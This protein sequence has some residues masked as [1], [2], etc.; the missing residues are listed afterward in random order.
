MSAVELRRLWSNRQPPVVYSSPSREI[1]LACGSTSISSI[2]VGAY[3]DS[4]IG[5]GQPEI[6][7]GEQN[8]SVSTQ[9]INRGVNVYNCVFESP[10]A[11]GEE[12]SLE[13]I[14]R[15]A[16]SQ[17]AFIYNDMLD[18]PLIS[19]QTTSEYNTRYIWVRE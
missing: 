7:I 18:T 6:K 19:P 2:L 5:D 13:I 4:L 1:P 8:C 11:V 14:Q 17:I 16:T 12:G 10:V 3:N 9:Q 15:N